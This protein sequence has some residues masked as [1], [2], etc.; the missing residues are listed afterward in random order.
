MIIITNDDG[1]DAIG[2]RSLLPIIK[3]EFLVFAPAEHQSGCG[4]TITVAQPIRFENRINKEYA[5]YGTPADC[6]RLVPQFFNDIPN[7]VLSGIN[8]GGNL[9]VDLYISGT[10][11]AAREAAIFGW[12]SIALSQRIRSGPIDWN[13]TIEMADFVLQNLFCRDLEKGYFWN[14]NFPHIETGKSFDLVDCQPSIDPLDVSFQ[15]NENLF[16]YTGRYANR[17]ITSG[18]D[19]DVC[20]SGNVSISK[21][22]L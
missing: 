17:K 9:G 10:A 13:F 8:F 14:V 3:E 4:H 22:R 5:I 2:L 18:T 11:A 1:I 12:K 16:Y 20:F 21:I 7:W 19:V 15:L 6:I